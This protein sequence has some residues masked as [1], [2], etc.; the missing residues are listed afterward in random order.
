MYRGEDL[1][2]LVTE[3]GDMRGLTDDG[4]GELFAALEENMELVMEEDEQERYEFEQ[5]MEQDVLEGDE[6]EAMEDGTDLLVEDL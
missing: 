1:G 5:D 3:Y 6:G 2:L 4:R